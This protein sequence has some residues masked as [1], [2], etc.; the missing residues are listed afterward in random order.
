MQKTAAILVVRLVLTTSAIAL[1]VGAVYVRPPVQL[2]LLT[3]GVLALVGSVA[4]TVVS[5]VWRMNVARRSAVASPNEALRDPAGVRQF[6]VY[7][8]TLLIGAAVL[9]LVGVSFAGSPIQVAL[10]SA[11]AVCGAVALL[12]ALLWIVRRRRVGPS[13]STSGSGAEP[14]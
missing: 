2:F 12:I 1:F 8:V 6:L 7:A 3:G 14:L 4:V 10:L 13:S 9:V 5:G 11:A